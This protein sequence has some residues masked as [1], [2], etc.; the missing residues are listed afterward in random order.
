MAKRVRARERLRKEPRGR[1]LNFKFMS[2]PSSPKEP[3]ESGDLPRVHRPSR[4]LPTDVVRPTRADVHLD[5]LRHNLGQLRKAT[6]PVPIWAVLKADAYGHG[7]KAVARTLERAG[8][9]GVCVALVEEG[10]ELREAGIGLPILV[11]GGYYGDA[12]HEL[13][14]HRLTPVLSDEGQV[15]ALAK[16]V[17]LSER[18]KFS[19]HVKV[20]TGMARLG[21]RPEEWHSLAHCLAENQQLE[22]AGLMTHLANADIDRADAMDEPLRLFEVAH[23]MFHAAGVRPTLRHMAN[24]GAL[25]RDS[26]THFQAV[27]PGVALFGVDPLAEM[28]ASLLSPSSAAFSPNSAAP[29]QRSAVRLRSTITVKSR[30]VSLRNLKVGDEVGYGGNFRAQRPSVIAT[31]PMGY[32]D[33]LSRSASNKG[34]V[35]LQGRRAPIVGNVSM[36]MVMIDVTDIPGIECGDEVVLLGRQKGEFGDDQ[37]TASEVA[38]WCGTI[39]WEVLTNISRRVPRFYREA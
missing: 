27:R 5:A 33:G 16:T 25:L 1:Y 15:R 17:A 23:Q 28:E 9:E 29:T 36:D 39:P 13:V 24:S 19:V 26:R 14:H 4:A 11:M 37:I 6:G 31:V 34:R 10:V 35:L 7:A 22:V 18:A 3:P 2:E 32:A 21:A 20:D 30:V 8:V 12:F 38:A